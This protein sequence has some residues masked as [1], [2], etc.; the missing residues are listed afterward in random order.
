MEQKAE[1]IGEEFIERLSESFN[2]PSWLRSFRMDAFKTYRTLPEEQSNLY[3]RY[4]IELGVDTKSLE[5]RMDTPIEANGLPMSEIASGIE[6]GYYY[7]STQ[8]ETIAS[9][10]IRDLESKGIVFCDLHEALEKHEKILETIFQEKAIKPSEDK[11]AA[12]NTAMFSTAW[13]IWVP[14]N[15]VLDTP[16]RLRFYLNS[17]R[18]HFSQVWVYAERGSE[19]TLLTEE[20]GAEIQGVASDVMEA[21][22]KDN[23][24]VRFSNIQNYSEKTAVLSNRK[25][26]C[27]KDSRVFWTLGYFGGSAER[28]RLESVFQRDGASAEDVEVVLG[29]GS[30]RFDIVSDL[31]H[32]GKFTKGRILSNG[33]LRDRSKSVFKGMIRIG[34]EAKGA[35]AYLA[36]HSIL[37][38]PD[39]KSDAIPGLEIE[40]NEVKA[41]HSASVAQIDQEQIFYIMTRGLSEDEAK[42]FIVLGF[43]EPAIS[44]ITS[45]ELRDTMRDVVEA[46][47]YGKK[48]LVKKE[49]KEVLFAEEQT[50]EQP[51]D[52]FEGHYKYR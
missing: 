41:T 39:S 44:R 38:S 6:S 42:K 46:K 37:L 21:Y 22:I 45:E 12:L 23:A 29:T 43:I 9:K 49:K 24:T 40:T 28:A 35:N 15:L 31:T 25:A 13:M 17:I 33:V 20:Y 30:Q 26:I 34:K 51:R 11:F 1:E 52:I 10:N 5:R 3:T 18:P 50:V 36:G 47:W 2:E 27:Q 14:E 32:L 16:L 48:G 4:G 8:S 19:V 7:V